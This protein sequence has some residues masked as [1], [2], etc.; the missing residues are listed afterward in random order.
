M[1]VLQVAL[2]LHSLRSALVIPWLWTL[3]IT[4]M[5]LNAPVRGVEEQKTR[6]STEYKAK[7]SQSCIG[8][9]SRGICSHLRKKAWTS[10]TACASSRPPHL[11]ALLLSLKIWKL[12][13]RSGNAIL[14]IP[15]HWQDIDT[16][17]TGSRALPPTTPATL[18]GND[19]ERHKDALLTLL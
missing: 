4:C 10:V 19:S 13:T 12:L 17:W 6:P 8:V 5:C 3:P 2:V 15:R 11:C 1:H 7:T 14:E 18:Y 16:T 9:A